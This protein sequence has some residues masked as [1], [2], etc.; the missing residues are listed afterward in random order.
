MDLP[1]PISTI[2][3]STIVGTIIVIISP[4]I[5]R[6]RVYWQSNLDSSCLGQKQLHPNVK[7]NRILANDFINYIHSVT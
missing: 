5:F 6:I 1:I 3:I 4:I 7:G 2:F